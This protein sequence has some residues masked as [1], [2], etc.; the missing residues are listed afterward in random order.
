MA[1]GVVATSGFESVNDQPTLEPESVLAERLPGFD[2]ALQVVVERGSDTFQLTWPANRPRPT[3]TLLTARQVR[4]NADGAM[5]G[6]LSATIPDLWAGSPGS[7]TV[8]NPD[9]LSYVWHDTDPDLLASIRDLGGEP[10]LWI[11]ERMEDGTWVFST[12]TQV[13][14]GVTAYAYGDWGV[15][16]HTES[17]TTGL[18]FVQV[19]APDGIEVARV[20]GRALGSL[21]GPD[22]GVL[23]RRGDGSLSVF[24]A[25]AEW[26]AMDGDILLPS[27]SGDLVA[28]HVD[29]SRTVISRAGETVA[30]AAGRPLR[31]VGSTGVLVATADG[32][33]FLDAGGG[34]F[35]RV[36][37][38]GT[39][40]D[41]IAGG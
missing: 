8:V 21:P 24:P 9:T 17:P 15:A 11:G 10:Q 41:A 38:N 14:R 29:G 20:E 2:R 18:F 27:P 22:G 12:F 26:P 34:Q 30:T 5:V 31:W 28:A 4:F 7:F 40:V 6:G 19:F 32:L 36:E 37:L 16:T 3:E 1:A 13:A 23:V 39:V 33:G 35:S 25:Q